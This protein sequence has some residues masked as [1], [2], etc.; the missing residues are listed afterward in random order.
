MSPHPSPHARNRSRRVRPG[1]PS[2]LLLAAAACGGERAAP[3][4]DAAEHSSIPAWEPPIEG[5]VVALAR[6]PLLGADRVRLTVARTLRGNAAAPLVAPADV[7][8][9]DDGRVVVLDGGARDLKLFDAD[10][11]LERV[12]GGEGSATGALGPSAAAV[13][14]AGGDAALVVE[15]VEGRLVRWA[16]DGS[17]VEVARLATHDGVSLGY[18]RDPRDGRVR[19]AFVPLRSAPGER[20]RFEPAL[21]VRPAAQRDTASMLELATELDSTAQVGHAG[22][23]ARLHW[24]LGDD[25]RVLV[26]HDGRYRVR[27]YEADGLP[28]HV[29][30]RPDSASGARPTIDALGAGPD[31]ETWVRRP[32]DASGAAGWDV[33]DRDGRYLAVVRL[34]AGFT[35][36]RIAGRMLVGHTVDASGEPIAQ[37]LRLELPTP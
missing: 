34:P 11:A 19:E 23:D 36:T 12:L 18:R 1:L 5:P 4:A 9:L 25:G 32:G 17:G 14:A 10:G 6:E 26:A 28:R 22:T 29:L 20:R 8:L 33:H 2:L 21:L 35:L 31:G 27:I 13:F 15:P 37:L 24:A 7:E 30:Q 3:P 16:L